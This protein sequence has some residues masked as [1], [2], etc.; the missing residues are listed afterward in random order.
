[1]HEDTLKYKLYWNCSKENLKYESI[2]I[3]TKCSCVVRGQMILVVT[4]IIGDRRDIHTISYYHE[5]HLLYGDNNILHIIPPFYVYNKTFV[6]MIWRWQHC[7]HHLCKITGSIESNNNIDVL[8]IIC[9]KKFPISCLNPCQKF[10]K[11]GEVIRSLS[12][13]ER[14]AE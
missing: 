12:T 11:V 13:L 1:M 4:Q 6:A 14:G 8:H 7:I 9:L 3:L 10:S 2:G 5:I